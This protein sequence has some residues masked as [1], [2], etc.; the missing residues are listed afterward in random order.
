M[1]LLHEAL[2]AI[3][4]V[5]CGG[6][7]AEI[8]DRV[9]ESMA[10]GLFQV[11]R[12]SPELVAA[13]LGDDQDAVGAAIERLARQ[14]LAGTGD[15]GNHGQPGKDSGCSEITKATGPGRHPGQLGKSSA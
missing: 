7:G 4:Y 10:M 12:D 8:V 5:Y 13:I 3:E 15:N 11:L 6:L 14:S 1:T 9:T 2:H